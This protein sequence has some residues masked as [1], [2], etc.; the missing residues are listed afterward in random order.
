MT[1]PT[2]RPGRGSPPATPRWV[3]IFVLIFIVFVLLVIALHVMGF[4][5]GSHGMG[6]AELFVSIT[7]R[8]FSA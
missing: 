8:Q 4:D 2:N 3:K 7:L 6:G 1:E 5:F